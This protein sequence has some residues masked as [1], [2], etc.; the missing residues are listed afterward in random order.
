[1]KRFLHHPLTQMCIGWIF[2]FT[3][4]LVLPVDDA[5]FVGQVVEHRSPT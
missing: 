2:L 4:W 5:P 1:M 3:V